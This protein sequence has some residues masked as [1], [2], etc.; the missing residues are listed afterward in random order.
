MIKEETTKIYRSWQF[1]HAI[2]LQD[3][4]ELYFPT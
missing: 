1:T 3:F 4:I 2:L